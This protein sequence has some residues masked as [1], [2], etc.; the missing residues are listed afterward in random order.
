MSL[1]VSSAGRALR[2][3]EYSLFRSW[4]HTPRSKSRT[5][6]VGMTEKRKCNHI[7]PRGKTAENCKSDT[8]FFINGKFGR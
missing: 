5:V 7:H 3:Q 2:Q 4:I 6:F 8:R 1:P